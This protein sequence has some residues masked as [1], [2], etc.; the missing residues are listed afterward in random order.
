MI[1]NTS[2]DVCLL[3]CCSLLPQEVAPTCHL[4][5]N[6]DDEKALIAG[7]RS[8]TSFFLLH[9][10]LVFF[11]E[12][13]IFRRTGGS[14]CVFYLSLT[15]LLST[16]RVTLPTHM[17]ALRVLQTTHLPPQH[18]RTHKQI[19][20]RPAGRPHTQAGRQYHGKQQSSQKAESRGTFKAPRLTR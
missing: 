3:C 9:S 14:K 12:P 8:T 2:C 4:N 17:P 15:I 20:S 5:V 19:W 16:E 1:N 7:A 11:A 6:I 18:P 13:H 10:Q